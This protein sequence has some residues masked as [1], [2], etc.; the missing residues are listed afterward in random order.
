MAFLAAKTFDL[1]RRDPFDPN[2]TQRITHIVELKWLDNGC[3]HFHHA[4]SLINAIQLQTYK[5]KT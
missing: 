1:C 4:H 3:Y 2:F 5:L